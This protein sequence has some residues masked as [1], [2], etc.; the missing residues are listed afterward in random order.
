[1][2]RSDEPISI[3]GFGLIEAGRI[4]HE[5]DL[6]AVLRDKYPVSPGHTL[7]IPKRAVV[8]FS[9]LTPEE[10]A[11]LMT[12]IDWTISRLESTL[13]PVPNGFNIGLNDGVAAGQTISL[14]STSTSSLTEAPALN[15]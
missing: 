8:R 13:L 3:P 11:R 2:Q 1:M 5:D 15:R 10:K 7:V 12:W 14:N 4:H 6:F 9:Q